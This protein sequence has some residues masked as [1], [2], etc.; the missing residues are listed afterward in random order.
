MKFQN[1]EKGQ[2]RE[3]KLTARLRQVGS[4]YI[5]SL[6]AI[7]FITIALLLYGYYMWYCWYREEGLENIPSKKIFSSTRFGRVRD[8]RV[9][10]FLDWSCEQQKKLEQAKHET[11]KNYYIETFNEVIP[12]RKFRGF[13]ILNPELPRLLRAKKEGVPVV[14]HSDQRKAQKE[15]SRYIYFHGRRFSVLRE[16][17]FKKYWY[18]KQGYKNVEDDHMD[19][20]IQN[21]L[22]PKLVSKHPVPK[23]PKKK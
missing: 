19:V 23:A 17:A 21:V 13:K 1:K 2:Q 18:E 6:L 22:P 8:G 15:I 3:K 9:R 7:T 10:D 14:L 20:V 12:R 5:E 16:Q 11:E 4:S